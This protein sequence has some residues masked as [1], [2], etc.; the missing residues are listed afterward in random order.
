MRNF[1]IKG[2][3]SYKAFDTAVPADFS[4]ATFFL[5]AAVLSGEQVELLGLD[6]SDSQPDKA[7][8]DYLKKM[9]ADIEVGTDSVTVRVI[10][11]RIFDH[12]SMRSLPAGSACVGVSCTGAGVADLPGISLT[13][14]PSSRIHASVVPTGI[15]S[16][17]A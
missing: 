10:A 3:Q 9:G 7:V 12:G 16:S 5:C 11:R 8:V 6:F 14:S 15:S 13:D 2:G 1:K 17:P 4:S